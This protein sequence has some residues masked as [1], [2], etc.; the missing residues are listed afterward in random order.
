MYFSTLNLASLLFFLRFLI[1]PTT[2]VTSDTSQAYISI[3][4]N[5]NIIVSFLRFFIV[6]LFIKFNTFTFKPRNYNSL[7]LF[8]LLVKFRF[9]VLHNN[10]MEI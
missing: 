8:L 2:F 1:T 4:Y 5:V 9:S 10:Y 6:T 7:C 3:R